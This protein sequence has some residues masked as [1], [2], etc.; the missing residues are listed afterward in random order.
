[1]RG[2]P[3]HAI[4]GGVIALAMASCTLLCQ[5]CSGGAAPA[6]EPAAAAP[7]PG[8]VTALGR[9]EPASRVLDIGAP[10]D[11]RVVRL[12]VDEGEE[13][14]QGQVL[15]HLDDFDE[16]EADRDRVASQ[17]AEA[18]TRFDAEKR[19]GASRVMEAQADLERIRTT[20]PLQLD[21]KRA[22]VRA[23]EV[24][25]ETADRDL[26]RRRTLHEEGVIAQ[27]QVDAQNLRARN[28]AETLAVLRAE[29][30]EIEA[31][32]ELERISAE[33]RLALARDAA[34]RD[35]A[36]VPL[37]SLRGSLAHAVARIE[38]AVIRA[39]VAG[40]VLKVL[41]LPGETVGAGPV[42]QMGDISAMYAVAE[43][44]ETDVRH[45]RRGQPVTVTSPALAGPLRGRVEQIGQVIYK[46]DVL[47]VDP[48]SNVDARVVEVRIRLDDAESAAGLSNLQV[49]VR[50]ELSDRVSP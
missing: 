1:M 8:A 48:A 15:F 28:A 5:G 17:V 49:D 33:T 4:G 20:G 27:E 35:V 7:A 19:L 22:A 12:S 45:V 32:V 44:Y 14:K 42:L 34:I 43:V 37:E 38:R 24:E 23:A 16:A 50:I 9:I 10:S 41:V 21:A 29:L 2:K 6:G 18:S 36:A 25:L 39:P 11:S 30:A 31:D 3:R 46:N 13:V 40:R 26:L 47:D